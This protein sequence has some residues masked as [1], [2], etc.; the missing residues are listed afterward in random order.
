MGLTLLQRPLVAGIRCGAFMNCA[1]INYFI[2]S[3]KFQNKSR[4]YDIIVR[5]KKHICSLYTYCYIIR[6]LTNNI[7]FLSKIF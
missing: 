3:E 2:V 6:N 5:I 1:K 7:T 4:V